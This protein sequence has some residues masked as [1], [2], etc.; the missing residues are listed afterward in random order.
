MEK[1]S[2][3]KENIGKM[4]LILMVSFFL[5]IK[6]LEYFNSLALLIT[7]TLISFI[8]IISMLKKEF[9]FFHK[10]VIL[11]F[12]LFTILISYGSF[13]KHYNK[14]KLKN[15]ETTNSSSK[16]NV[17][18]TDIKHKIPSDFYN[19]TLYLKPYLVCRDNFILNKD[20]TFTYT[21]YSIGTIATAE[22][23]I[24]KGKLN[25]NGTIS[26]IG[27]N[28][29]KFAEDYEPTEILSK[30]DIGKYG[31]TNVINLYSKSFNTI[32]GS[33]EENSVSFAHEQCEPG[34]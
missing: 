25:I 19:T 29:Y 16:N 31:D 3:I 15:N 32:N 8:I 5:M 24:I 14:S 18:E 17:S 7:I 23:A 27:S 6:S 4:I 22:K 33:Y 20:R 12:A 9:S 2:T 10:L 30:W 28:D 1:Q 11:T 21:L 13:N 26:F 34:Y